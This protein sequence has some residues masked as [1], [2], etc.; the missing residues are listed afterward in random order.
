MTNRRE[1]LKLAGLASAGFGMTGLTPK[2]TPSPVVER[3]P[4]KVGILHSLSGTMAISEKSTV[5]AEMLAIA[6]INKAGGVLGRPIEAIVEDGASDWP[7]FAEKAEKLIVQDQVVTIFGGWTSASR[8]SILPILESTDHMLWYPLVYEGQECSQNIFYTGSV[9]NQQVEPAVDWALKQFRG[10]PVFLLGSDYVY[11]RTLNTIIKGQ[12]RSRGGRQVG[13]EYIPLGNIEV[14]E[15]FEQIRRRMPNG[16]VILNSLNGDTNIAFFKE[17]QRRSMSPRQYPSI[18]LSI[19]EE[20]VRAIG[21]EY[22]E[23]HYVAWSYFQTVNTAANRQF[24]KAF[25]DQYGS[26]RLVNDPMAAAYTAVYLWKQAVEKAGTAEDLSKVR[27]AAL[28]TLMNAPE[29]F[30][31]MNPNH[32]LSR[33]ARIGRVRS[34]G[35]FEV[36]YQSKTA[37]APQPWSRMVTDTKN[38]GCDWSDPKKG[39]KYRLK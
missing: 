12:L 38:F 6:Q 16:G 37:I 21:T 8:K 28:G 4:I 39:G 32:H 23:G 20:E 3:S 13:E 36:V 14:E 2:P 35:L 25:K 1:F 29:G 18:S 31:R 26:D 11:P 33:W 5:D 17:L 19:A 10:K 30:V 24:V 7:T 27:K 22:L 34:D 15:A 9:P